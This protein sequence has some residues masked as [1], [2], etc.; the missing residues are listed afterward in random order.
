MKPYGIP[1]NLDVQWP[2]QADCACYGLKDSRAKL[3]NR[4]GERHST[5]RN[6]DSKAATRRYWKRK[7]RKQGEEDVREQYGDC[8]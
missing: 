8:E 3:P 4:N 7:A 1:R 6:K 5:V 2:D